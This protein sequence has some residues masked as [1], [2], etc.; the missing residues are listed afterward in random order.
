[1][2]PDATPLR[3]RIDLPGAAPRDATHRDGRT[4]RIGRDAAC[5]VHVAHPSVSRIHVELTFERGCWI[6][7]DAGS[8]NG[9]W[10]DGE[11]VG[12][13]VR[14][15]QSTRLRL[16]RDGPEVQVTPEAPRPA[17][18]AKRAGSDRSTP[19]TSRSDASL[20]DYIR[21]YVTDTAGGGE[22]TIMVR[23]AV[24]TVQRTQ[25]RRYVVLVGGALVLAAAA[26]LVAWQKH[27]EVAELRRA[28]D[29]I[30]TQMKE[31]DLQLAQIRTIVETV[32]DARIA[33]QLDRLEASRRRLVDVYERHLDDLRVYD[34]VAPE[35]QVIYRVARAFNESEVTMPPEFLWEVKETIR[36][37]W[38]SDAGRER[39]L[40]AV[41]RAARN[42]HTAAITKTLQ[43][44][45][46][47][48]HFFYL[49]LQ[50]SNFDVGAVGPPTRWGRAK[51]MWQ[52][53]PSTAVRF[54]LYPGA[55]P[56]G[57]GSEPGDERCDFA[58]S[59]AA[60]ARY[61][62]TIYSTLAQA[63]G[64]LVVASYN[65]GEGRVVGRLSDLANPKP[66]DPD[67]LADLPEDPAARS[68]WRFLREFRDRIPAETRDYVLKVFSAAVIGEDPA[69]FGFAI[70]R[71]LALRP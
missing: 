18:P 17:P 16:G 48:P 57:E 15:E 33:T 61:L 31:L 56:D 51:G 37:Y 14:L 60:A 34:A 30:F 29:G 21:H 43:A 42:G 25:R 65:W 63:S 9:T 66:G 2:V 24:A 44:H 10:I 23:R 49:A 62:Q 67:P 13:A 41:G 12:T 58:K 45:G 47:T 64:L 1:V 20:D 11:R 38:Q 68:Y 26:G 22:H 39:F 28:A 71:P 7:R 3:I 8:T 40:R 70:E 52:L 35:D 59:T 53:I 6:A 46:L 27:R 5:E 54:D 55:D 32:G 36:T 19:S 50:E 4:I 69:R